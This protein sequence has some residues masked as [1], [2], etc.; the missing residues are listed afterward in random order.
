M[1]TIKA[2]TADNAMIAP[3]GIV[4]SPLKYEYNCSNAG[5]DRRLY[6]KV[7]GFEFAQQPADK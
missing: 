5:T 6:N 1:K 4:L 7:T 2:I 3:F